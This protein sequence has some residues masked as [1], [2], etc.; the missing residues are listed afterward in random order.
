MNEKF[1]F[2]I[3]ISLKLVPK[4]SIDNNHNLFRQWLCTEQ[5]K[6]IIRNNGECAPL[7][8]DELTYIY[9]ESTKTTSMEDIST[10][11]TEKIKNI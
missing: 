4:D 3:R 6:A 9:I 2:S 5:A 10:G 1:C 7:W 8:G 11:V